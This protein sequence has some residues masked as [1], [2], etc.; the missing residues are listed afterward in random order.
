VPGSDRV[1]SQ[2]E[3]CI[4]PPIISKQQKEPLSPT[5]RLGSQDSLEAMELRNKKRN[6]VLNDYLNELTL[7]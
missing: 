3:K 7:D 6:S 1:R 5:P 4:L 2:K